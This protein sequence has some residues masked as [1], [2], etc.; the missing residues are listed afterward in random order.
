M[1][2]HKPRIHE[3]TTFRNLP[4]HTYKLDNGME[5]HGFYNDTIKAMKLDFIFESGQALQSKAFL[6]AFTNAML[7]E[8]KQ[9]GK[10][11][12]FEET[13]DYYGIFLQ[14]KIGRKWSVFSFYLPVM[15]LEN[16]LPVAYDMLFDPDFT[17]DSLT[18]LR[19]KTRQ[20]LRQN[21]KRT[22]YNAAAYLKTLIWGKNNP[23]GFYPEESALDDITL[24]DIERFYL[25]NY[26][27]SCRIGISGYFPKDIKSQLN[28]HFGQVAVQY[29]S[30][31]NISNPRPDKP[32]NH[33]IAMDDKTQTSLKWGKKIIGPGHP[34]YFGFKLVDTIFGGFFGSRLMRNIR[35]DKAYT[36]G[37]Y[38]NIK[39]SQYGCTHTI[40]TDVGHEYLEDTIRQIE[41][42]A[43]VL[44]SDLVT[45][46][47]LRL[48][49]N[50]M[51]GE[52]L[53]TFDGAF[54]HASIYRY[55]MEMNLDFGY[56]ADFIRQIHEITPS[57]IRD[58]AAKH[59]DTKAMHKVTA[60]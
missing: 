6:S 30:V 32:E 27:T 5:I 9:N 53:S 46:E 11:Q 8:G 13:L 4:V 58:I 44:K 26:I 29:K 22:D 42:E 48:V 38:S 14:Q 41:H 23:L 51:S 57:E 47:E 10:S 31:E 55:L 15:Y 56:Y 2:H 33:H 50:Y 20:R 54:K 24:E 49:Q 45:E 12:S 35:E 7:R 25:E 52:L 1:T 36:Y 34:D 39:P 18:F 60:G 59:L 21:L 3:I 37:I 16:L 28:K 19:E 17:E 40:S 43:D